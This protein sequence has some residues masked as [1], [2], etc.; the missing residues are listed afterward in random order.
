MCCPLSQTDRL[1]CVAI[2]G[3]IES[4]EVETWLLLY[5][6][7]MEKSISWT[8]LKQWNLT[9]TDVQLCWRFSLLSVGAYSTVPVYPRDERGCSVSLVMSAA[10]FKYQI[11]A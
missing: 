4:S 10:R 11:R 2:G 5:L 8:S 9:L 7:D 1:T 6:G 3:V